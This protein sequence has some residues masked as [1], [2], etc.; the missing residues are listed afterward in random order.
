MRLTFPTL[1]TGLALI[2]AAGLAVAQNGPDRDPNVVARHNHMQL[3][4]YNLG[5]IGAMAKGEI[6]YDADQAAIAAARLQALA[7]M[8]ETGYWPDGTSSEDLEE[9]R[10]LPVLFSERERFEDLRMDLAAAAEQMAAVAGDG[11]AALAPALGAVG[12][13]CGACHETYRVP[14]D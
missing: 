4:A 13:A 3:Y 9:S 8:D 14:N 11:Q 6:P 12:K 10:A 2:A 1:A 7:G 5:Q